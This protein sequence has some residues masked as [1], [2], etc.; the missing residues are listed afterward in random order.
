MADQRRVE[1]LIKRRV[2][3]LINNTNL[4]F[5]IYICFKLCE[6]LLIRIMLSKFLL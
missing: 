2:D 3:P 4:V 5:N 6:T 1:P